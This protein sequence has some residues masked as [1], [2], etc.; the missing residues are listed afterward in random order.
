MKTLILLISCLLLT[1][2]TQ[3]LPAQSLNVGIEP[4]FPNLRIARPIVVTHAGDQSGRIFVAS[5]LGT[6]YTF[7][8][9]SDVEEATV[10]FDHSAKVMYKDKEN[11]EGLLGFA[12]H[13]NY[14]KTGEFFLFYTA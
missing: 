12:F 13:P 14:A 11:E 4:A 6:I 7:D 5:Q 9:S 1:T 2:T 3:L 8:N 10:F